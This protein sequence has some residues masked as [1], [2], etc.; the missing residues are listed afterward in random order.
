MQVIATNKKAY[1]DYFIEEK[2]EAG[3]ILFGSEVK[4]IRAGKVN[5]KDGFCRIIGGE[6]FLFN[7][8][9]ST[10]ST[11]NKHYYHEETRVR[12]LLLKRKQIDKLLKSV[13]RDGMTIV[14]LQL[15]L[16]DANKVK[17]EIALVKGKHTYD[18]R[19]SLK[20]KT[21]K[22]DESRRE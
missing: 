12:K 16:S 4:A 5:L 13:S 9:I 6:L 10:L 7:I 20:D 15:Y 1:F 17:I 14:P 18:K 22:L 8:H 3:V 19:Q 21:L 2:I 11:T